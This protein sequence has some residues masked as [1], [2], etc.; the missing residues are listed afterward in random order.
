[1]PAVTALLLV[2]LGLY[3]ILGRPASVSAAIHKHEKMQQ[4]EIPSPENAADSCCDVE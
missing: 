3:A 2:G 1:V 4:S